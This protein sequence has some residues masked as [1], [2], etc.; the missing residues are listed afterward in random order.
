MKSLSFILVFLSLLVGPAAA[1]GAWVPVGPP[2]GTAIELLLHPRNPNILWAVTQTA[3][4]FKSVDGGAS[5]VPSRQGLI[6]SD[7][8]A[9]AV[10]PSQ[11]NILYAW[12]SGLYSSPD[13]GRTWTAVLPC[14]ERPPHR[15][16]AALFE[17]RQLVVD[18]QDPQTVYAVSGGVLKSVDGGSTWRRTKRTETTFSLVFHPRDPGALYATGNDG[19]ARSEDGGASWTSLSNGIVRDAIYSLVIDPKNPRRMWATGNVS[20]AVYRTGDGGALWRL[21]ARGLRG[22][23]VDWLHT[24]ALAPAAG[25][26]LPILWVGTRTGA[27]RSLDGGVTW[28]SASPD[29]SHRLILSLLAHPG[30]PGVLW[31]AS[32]FSFRLDRPAGVFKSVDHGASWRAAS[33]GL[34]AFPISSLAFDPVTPGVLWAGSRAGGAFRSTDGGATWTERHGHLAFSEGVVRDL[35]IDPQAP[36][37]VWMAPDRGVFVTEDGGAT[38]EARNEGLVDA[39]GSA[40]PILVL[41]LAPANPSVAYAAMMAR[42]FKTVDAGAHW[43]ELSVPQVA[44]DV[45]VDPRDPD[46]VFV[47]TAF[48]IDQSREAG[49]LW[50]SRDGGDTWEAAPLETGSRPVRSLASD[51]RNPDVL[52]AGGDGGIFRSADGGRTWQ[53]VTDLQVFGEANLAVSPTGAVWASTPAGIFRSPDGLSDWTAVPGIE[54]FFIQGIAVD[55]HDPDNVL[56]ATLAGIFRWQEGD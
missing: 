6:S 23:G 22:A 30:R 17:V 47:A 35:A 53:R 36:D 32:P 56:V 11:P 21:S 34:L 5:W 33:R 54:K 52:Y 27:F 28:T 3:G 31:A 42:L 19:V 51:P 16:C 40:S 49:A 24:L 2:G 29:L 25:R 48:F 55:P 7:A 41:R 50:I 18:P 37:T 20:R 43:T 8:R 10:A 39:S 15:G 9:L 38:W 14:H 44:A 13:G 45:L 46:V 26:S 4:V 1:D 12:S